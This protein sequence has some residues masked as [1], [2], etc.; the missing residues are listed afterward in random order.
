MGANLVTIVRNF[1]IQTVTFRANDDDV[2]DGCV[3]PGR[4]RLLRFDFLSHNAGNKD[5]HIGPPP[6]PPPPLPP[7]DSIFVWSQSHGHYHIKDFNQYHLLN[8]DSQE[9]AP[10]FK[11]AFCL[12]DIEQMDPQAGPAKYSCGDQGVTAGWADV[13]DSSLPCQ[14]IIIDGVPDGDYRLVATTNYRG[15]APEDRYNDNS[16]L[17]G[18]RIR[19]N[20][21]TSIPLVWSSWESLGGTVTSAPTTAAWG[22]NRLDVFALGQSRDLLHRWWNG[23]RWGGWESLGGTLTS[24]PSAVSWGPTAWTS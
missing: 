18:V 15:V 2:L 7:R 4:R 12:M 11:Q 9:V 16:V 23:T 24:Q 1:S 14:Y 22:P 13:Y 5:L 8:T 20:T 21:A 10:G 19:G 3:T 17:A 6:P